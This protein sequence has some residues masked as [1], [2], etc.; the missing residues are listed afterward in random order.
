MTLS[1]QNSYVRSDSQ[2]VATIGVR[3]LIVVATKD[4]VL[5]AHKDRDQDIREIVERLRRAGSSVV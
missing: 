2:L 1:T 4:A 3:D 5:V